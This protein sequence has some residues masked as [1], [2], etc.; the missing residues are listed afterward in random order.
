MRRLALTLGCLLLA[1]PV[2]AQTAL[3]AA[4]RAYL[5]DTAQGSA[6][7][8]RLAQTAAQSVKRDDVRAYASRL[9]QDHAAYSKALGQLAQAKGIV[10]PP[11]MKDTDRTRL[12]A[13]NPITDET[14]LNEAIRL[15]AE[16]KKISAEQAARTAD[17]DIKAFLRQFEAAD[18]EHER[19]ALS[20]RR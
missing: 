16:D 4:D 17:P 5:T 20:L 3:T 7:E 14:F 1:S 19:V 13:F 11:E 10:L 15:N 6:Y 2:L 8:L 12:A 18:S 9:V